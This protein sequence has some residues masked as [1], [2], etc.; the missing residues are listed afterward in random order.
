M[1]A[2]LTE[3]SSIVVT[4]LV[5]LA[6]FVAG[7]GLGRWLKRRAGVRLGFL[8]LLFCATLVVWVSLEV[9]TRDFSH[10]VDVLRALRAANVLLGTLFVM[11]LVRRYYWEGWF[12]RQRKVKAPKF[13]SQLVG[14]MFFIV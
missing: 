5:G 13:L 14:L 3:G 6:T 9:S 8:Y 2:E 1:L 10:R 7:V 12:E 11:A 4:V